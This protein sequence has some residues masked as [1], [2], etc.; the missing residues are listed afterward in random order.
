[1]IKQMR[2]SYWGLWASNYPLVYEEYENGSMIRYK[3]QRN[4]RLNMIWSFIIV[5]R[6]IQ[7]LWIER[8]GAILVLTDAILTKNN[9]KTGNNIGDWKLLGR[10]NG[11]KIDSPAVWTQFPYQLD[12]SQWVKHSGYKRG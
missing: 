3:E 11:V 8:N 10:Y 1:M 6:V 2:R 9:I 5:H 12:K 7:R 4:A